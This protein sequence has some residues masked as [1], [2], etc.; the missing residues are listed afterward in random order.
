MLQ[1]NT[2]PGMVP[3]RNVVVKSN[4]VIFRR[5]QVQTEVNIGGG[6]EPGTFRFEGNHWFAED[7]PAASKPN[8][9]TAEKGGVITS[10]RAGGLPR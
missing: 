5:S 9:P 2:A 4:R 1:E 3:C 6:T 8:L 7:R 10:P